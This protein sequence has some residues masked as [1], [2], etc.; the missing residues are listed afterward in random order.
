[1]KKSRFALCAL[2]LVGAALALPHTREAARGIAGRLIDNADIK[3]AVHILG[4]G[5]SGERGFFDA[6]SGA[7]AAA[8]LDGRDGDMEVSSPGA[9]AMIPDGAES[10]SEA[11]DSALI[12]T[13]SEYSDGLV[14]AGAPMG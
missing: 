12:E 5:V 11:V 2:A 4:E 13:R 7:F 10:F 1:M 6:L 3:E 14:P 9:G 8:F